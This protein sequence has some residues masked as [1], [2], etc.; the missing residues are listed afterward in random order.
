MSKIIMEAD[1]LKGILHQ[2]QTEDGKYYWISTREVE[3]PLGNGYETV[4]VKCRM[5][6]Y[7]SRSAWQNASEWRHG[8]NAAEAAQFHRN[9]CENL[10]VM[11]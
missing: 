8:K 3:K 6:G 5:N 1:S 7:V 9:I 2:V 10:E 4:A 11:I